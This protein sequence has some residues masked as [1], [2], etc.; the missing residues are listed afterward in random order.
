MS[1]LLSVVVAL[2]LLAFHRDAP[3]LAGG[4]LPHRRRPGGLF[5]GLGVGVAPAHG[6]VAHPPETQDGAEGSGQPPHPPGEGRTGARQGRSMNEWLVLAAFVASGILVAWY[7]RG[8]APRSEAAGRRLDRTYLQG[9][10]LL[11]NDQQDAAIDLFVR[12]LEV[13]HETVEIHLALGKMFRQ[14]G[15][16]ERA[17]RRAR[18]APLEACLVHRS[19]LRARRSPFG[20]HRFGARP[21]TQGRRSPLA[22][23]R[24]G[25]GHAAAGGGA[26]DDL[27]RAPGATA[28]FGGGPGEP[29]A[30]DSR[31]GGP[32]RAAR[33]CRPRYGPCW[34]DW[35]RRENATAAMPA[36]STPGACIGVAPAA[37]AG[38]P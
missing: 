27:L 23:A 16:V 11:L 24:P 5:A 2:V 19:G 13:N 12:V 34:R 15:E 21:D 22:R 33:S 32:N 4:D 9:L 29:L 36:A 37:K 1:R 18:P 20:A 6:A 38:G 26:F 14:R 25:P 7:R 31:A 3:R 30:G 10:N 17:I 8:V 28:A 35:R